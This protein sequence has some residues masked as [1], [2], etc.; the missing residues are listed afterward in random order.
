MVLI[1][2]IYYKNYLNMKEALTDVQLINILNKCEN[3]SSTECHVKSFPG[4][5]PGNILS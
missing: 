3:N 4:G 5:L 2:L 1:S